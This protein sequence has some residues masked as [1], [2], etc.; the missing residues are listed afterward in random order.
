MAPLPDVRAIT[1]SDP[2]TDHDVVVPHRHAISLRN[3]IMDLGSGGRRG[4]AWRAGSKRHNAALLCL[5]CRRIDVLLHAML[6]A[7]L[8]HWAITPQGPHL[9]GRSGVGL[10]QHHGRRRRPRD[11][12]DRHP[13]ERRQSGRSCHACRSSPGRFQYGPFSRPNADRTPIR[14]APVP[15]RR[16]GRAAD[17]KVPGQNFRIL[18]SS[19]RPESGAQASHTPP[20]ETCPIAEPRHLCSSE[21][22]EPTPTA[23]GPNSRAADSVR[24]GKV[25]APTPKNERFRRSETCAGGAGGTRTHGR[26]IMSPSRILATLVDHCPSWPFPQVR[27]GLAPQ[28]LSALVSLF[29][30]LCPTSVQNEPWKD[31]PD[32]LPRRSPQ[33]GSAPRT[34]PQRISFPTHGGSAPAI[35]GRA[36]VVIAPGRWAT[37]RSH[38][39]AVPAPVRFL[40]IQR[41]GRQRSLRHNGRHAP[42]EEGTPTCRTGAPVRHGGHAAEVTFPVSSSG[43]RRRLSFPGACHVQQRQNGR[44]AVSVVST[45]SP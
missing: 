16:P 22:G 9:R 35:G 2:V 28:S 6:H 15:T 7:M 17:P 43:A 4:P 12:H 45:M 8:K 25:D 31:K 40:M 24:S 27:Q 5:T 44:Q 19:Q 33:L 13:P 21:Q 23:T 38:G 32:Q 30:S 36:S 11:P 42:P 10:H 20:T 3:R 1:S 41:P 18:V 14:A 34:R 39:A 29:R 26:R 37:A